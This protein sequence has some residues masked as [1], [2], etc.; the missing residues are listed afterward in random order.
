MKRNR[1][2]KGVVLLFVNSLLMSMG[3]YA[4]I[5]YLAYYITENLLFTPFIAGMV[6]MVRQFSQQGTTFFFGAIG[7]IFG[8]KMIIS[9]GLFIRGVGFLMFAIATSIPG[10]LLAAIVSGLGGS[11]FEP[12]S[13]AALTELTPLDERRRVFSIDKIIKNIGMVGAA[14][15]GAMLI[16]FPFYYLCFVS[17]GLFIIGGI[18]TYFILPDINIHTDTPSFK[19]MLRTVIKDR[20]FV[21]FTCL[22]TGYWFMFIQLYLTIPIY[23]EELTG[24]P[25]IVSGL[26]FTFAALIIF[27]Q[28]PIQS[29]IKNTQNAVCFGMMLMGFGLVTIGIT[30]NIAI[31]F[32]GFLLFAIGVMV[33]EPAIYDLTALSSQEGMTSSYFG[34]FYFSMA[35]GGGLSQGIG[36]WLLQTGK[37]IGIPSLLWYI[38]G[39]VALLSISGL[40]WLF[41]YQRKAHLSC[42]NTSFN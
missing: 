3:F 7:D 33:A 28:Y 14:L 5:P 34:F 31:F 10:L 23:A 27:I 15:A 25:K 11:L 21:I 37:V 18:L 9:L 12:A 20:F 41:K 4:L 6:L 8:Y 26:Y 38:C 17:G 30:A 19:Q 29:L 40:Y 42:S 36:G 13:K 22:M 32:I 35:I 1:L 16:E 24:T 39:I 2:P